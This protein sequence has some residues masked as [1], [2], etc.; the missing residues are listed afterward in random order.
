MVKRRRRSRGLLLSH[1]L[2]QDAVGKHWCLNLGYHG[3]ECYKDTRLLASE[4]GHS[5]DS[6]TLIQGSG[7]SGIACEQNK[8]RTHL[9]LSREVHHS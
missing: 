9:G 6:S 8:L 4:A 7:A 5:T 2:L 1:A 3:Q